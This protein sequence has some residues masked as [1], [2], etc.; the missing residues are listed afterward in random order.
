MD[1]NRWFFNPGWDSNAPIGHHGNLLI[2][3]PGHYQF[4]EFVRVGIPLTLLIAAIVSI[5]APMLWPG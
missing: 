4:S 2:Y 1:T 3:G 5:M